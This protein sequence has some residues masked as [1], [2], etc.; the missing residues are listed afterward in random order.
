MKTETSTQYSRIFKPHFY[1]QYPFFIAM[2]CFTLFMICQCGNA[3]K[4]EGEWK[5]PMPKISSFLMNM[6]LGD[7]KLKFHGNEVIR[8]S[9]YGEFH[10]EYKVEGEKILLKDGVVLTIKSDSIILY[11]FPL[12]QFTQP[13]ESI[14]S[15]NP[16][17]GRS[18]KSWM[19]SVQFEPNQFDT[20]SQCIVCRKAR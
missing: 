6:D 8:S 5:C 19:P 3:K 11:P 20:T 9:K 10:E 13:Y 4:L 17:L 1:R 7:M 12:T 16:L 15:N 2:S 18:A 14:L